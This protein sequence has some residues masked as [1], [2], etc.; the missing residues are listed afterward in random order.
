MGGGEILSPPPRKKPPRKYKNFLYNYIP[1]RSKHFSFNVF[2]N[3]SPH[4]KTQMRSRY[5]SLLALS[6]HS[7]GFRGRKKCVVNRENISTGNNGFENQGS[8][9]KNYILTRLTWLDFLVPCKWWLVQCTVIKT[10]RLDKSL[11]TR[12]Q[13]R[14][15]MSNWSPCIYF[16]WNHRY[17]QLKKKKNFSLFNS[18]T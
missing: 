7:Q 17:P 10:C 1:K 16:F 3:T 13:K 5:T 11:L 8:G 2:F 4:F 18:L 15:A 14:T 9:Y 6:Q 12:Y